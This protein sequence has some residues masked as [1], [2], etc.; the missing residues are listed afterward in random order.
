MMF[1][2]GLATALLLSIEIFIPGKTRKMLNDAYFVIV[3]IGYEI[4]DIFERINDNITS[5]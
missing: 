5:G 2:F 3:R 1:Y 4:C